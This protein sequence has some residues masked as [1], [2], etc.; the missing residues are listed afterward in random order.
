M[1]FREVFDLFVVLQTQKQT[2]FVAQTK[3]LEVYATVED[4]SLESRHHLVLPL[5]V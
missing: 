3:D 5:H 2:I 4:G 1:L